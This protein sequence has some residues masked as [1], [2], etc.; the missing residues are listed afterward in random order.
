M[1]ALSLFFRPHHFQYV[2]SGEPTL[3]STA[4]LPAK[5]FPAD[6]TRIGDMVEVGAAGL[7]T[8]EDIARRVS[9]SGGAALFID[10]GAD[11]PHTNTL[12]AVQ[13]HEFKH[14]LEQPGEVDLTAHIDF[15][16]MRLMV[17]RASG[18]SSMNTSNQSESW[19]DAFPP[20]DLVFPPASS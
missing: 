5:L 7:A 10:Y 15:K 4:F 2:L 6:A 19:D 1:R 14:V 11:H 20:S 8:V 18:K 13:R 12:Q 17:E 9:A 3:A 16:A